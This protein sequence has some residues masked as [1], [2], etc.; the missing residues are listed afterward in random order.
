M[1]ASGFSVLASNIRQLLDPITRDLTPFRF[2]HRTRPI[3]SFR[4][5][6]VPFAR[7]K[8]NSV[9]S[10]SYVNKQSP[11]MPVSLCRVSICIRTFSGPSRSS[12]SRANLPSYPVTKARLILVSYRSCHYSSSITIVLILSCA[13]NTSKLAVP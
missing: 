12:S 8:G 9:V 3:S 1:R 6:H 4:L 11:I 2:Y 5:S 10:R 7:A 13:F